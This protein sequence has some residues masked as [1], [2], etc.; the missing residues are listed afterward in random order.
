MVTQPGSL[1]FDAELSNVAIERTCGVFST[2]HLRDTS[3]GDRICMTP[4][5]MP[6]PLFDIC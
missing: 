1:S 6:I 5:A 4:V 3:T 2:F